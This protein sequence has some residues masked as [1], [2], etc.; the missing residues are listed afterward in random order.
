MHIAVEG[1]ERVVLIDETN[2]VIGTA[3]KSEIHT[4]RTPLHRGVSVFLFDARQHLLLQRRSRK[5]KTWPLV[6]S[7]SCCGHPAPDESNCQAVR[8]RLSVELGIS[9]AEIHEVLSDYRYRARQ[10]KISENEICPV[11]IAFSRQA[12]DINEDEVEEVR[13]IAWRDFTREI[14]ACPQKYTPWC[15]EEARLLQKNRLFEGLLVASAVSFVWRE[16]PRRAGT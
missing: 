10:G 13:W 2:H 3:R 7:N 4:Q 9:E 12:P 6:W 16:E 14:A 15:V 1:E 5:K 8:R 11:F